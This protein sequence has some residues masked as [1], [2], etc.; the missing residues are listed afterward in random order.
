MPTE[1]PTGYLP[2]LPKEPVFLKPAAP[3]TNL[4]T[5]LRA[6]AEEAGKERV[7][8]RLEQF[9]GAGIGRTP[10]TLGSIADIVRGSV[11]P[12]VRSIFSDTMTGVK[13]MQEAKQREIDRT[14]GRT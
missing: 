14:S 1:T 4:R 8:G 10:G 11:R 5:A 9:Q 7:A 13:E 12:D 6:P 2:P 3:L